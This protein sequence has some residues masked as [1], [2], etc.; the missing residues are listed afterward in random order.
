M[1]PLG[2]AMTADTRVGERFKHLYVVKT[3]SIGVDRESG[4]LP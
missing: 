3:G 2:V 1:H 4:A